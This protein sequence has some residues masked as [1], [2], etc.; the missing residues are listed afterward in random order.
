[1]CM[2]SKATLREVKWSELVKKFHFG[3]ANH[4]LF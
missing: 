1:L 3:M 2:N 4:W